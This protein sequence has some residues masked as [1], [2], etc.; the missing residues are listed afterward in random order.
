MLNTA[1]LPPALAPLGAYKQFIVYRKVQSAKPGKLDKLPF[2]PYTTEYANA[3]DPAG[4]FDAVT[5]RA[6]ADAYG[7]EYDVGFVLTRNDPF[8]FIDIDGC[9][10]TDGWS[11]LA[12]EMLQRF[13]GAA[14]EV[15]V[16]GRGLHIIG[17]G[18]APPHKRA[19]Q[20][21]RWSYIRRIA[22]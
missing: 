22:L 6:L 2:N 10:L 16:S 20:V 15:S 12:R 11:P 5:A 13:A 14:V 8:F 17:T 9:L 19:G 1:C 7:A 18:A 21:Y 4:W 3:H